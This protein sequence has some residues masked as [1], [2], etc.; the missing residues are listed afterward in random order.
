MNTRFAACL[1]PALWA[2]ALPA[3]AGRPLSSDDAATTE[4]R[5]CQLETWIEHANGTN[6]L[7]LAP[8][9][10]IAA[11]IELGADYTQTHPRDSAPRA[12]GLALKWAPAAWAHSTA[13][14]ELAFGLKLGA[15]FERPADS[16]WQRSGAGLLG[17]ASWQAH[18]DWA[19]HANLG[20]ALDRASDTSATLLNLAIAWTPVDQAL[21]FVETQT[22]SRREVFGATTHS[23]GARWWLLKDRLG[24][25]LTAH[26]SSGA[27]TR[28][29]LGLGWYGM[30]F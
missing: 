2:C 15:G 27:S 22:N 21:L 19:V 23:S 25:D 13:A 16:G 11:G 14:G 18:A 28:W 17:L 8:A 4:P 3:W 29:T 6:A 7:T 20:A 12:A 1:A 10:G 30:S 9:C 26:R 24:L 5:S